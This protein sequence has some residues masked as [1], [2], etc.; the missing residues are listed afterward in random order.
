M[1]TAKKPAELVD[2][3]NPM[4]VWDKLSRTDPAHTKPF[5]RPG[6]SGTQI[7]PTYRLQQM[8]AMF[9]PVG[10][11]WSILEPKFDVIP[12]YGDEKLVFCTVGIVFPKDG[13]VYNPGTTYG[14]GGDY[15]V[16]NAKDEGA[17][18]RSTDEAFKMAFTDALGNAMKTLG[19][20]ADVFMGQMDDAKYVRQVTEEIAQEKKAAA[21][22]KDPELTAEAIDDYAVMLAKLIEDQKTPEDVLALFQVHKAKLTKL[23]HVDQGTSN[24]LQAQFK[25]RKEAILAG[26]QQAAE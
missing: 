24:R 14:V 4:R 26:T 25:R 1:A 21:V 3:A 6:F 5:K 9:G 16:R 20:G 7:D 2:D 17:K 15:I 10:Q 11:A 19:L 12:G 23:Q 13:D 8:T 18:P 22:A